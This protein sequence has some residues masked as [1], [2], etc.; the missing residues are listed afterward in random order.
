M[1]KAKPAPVK[2]DPIHQAILDRAKERAEENR[3]KNKARDAA[4]LKALEKDK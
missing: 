4:A 1:A 3:E 2:P